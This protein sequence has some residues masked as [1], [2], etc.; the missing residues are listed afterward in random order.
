MEKTITTAKCKGPRKH[1]EDFNFS[2]PINGSNFKGWLIAVA[3]GHS[4]KEVAKL[5]SKRIGKIFKLAR[6]HH[7]KSA[8]KKLVAQLHRETK[9]FDDGSTLSVALIIEKPENVFNATIAIL[10]DSPV[11]VIDQ[12]GKMHISPEHNVRSNL[13]EREAAK[14]RGGIY[15][16]KGYMHADVFGGGTQ[17]SR[18]LGSVDLKKIQSREPEI[19]SIPDPRWVLVASDGLFDPNHKDSTRLINEIKEYATRAANADALMAWAERR[20]LSDNTTAVVWK[21]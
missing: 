18:A 15:G 6:A 1:Q 20:G 10:G 16:S 11:I 5:C 17:L 4:G 7:A 12:S 8:L 19:Y 9:N 2:M 13:K 21:K 14:E 3:D